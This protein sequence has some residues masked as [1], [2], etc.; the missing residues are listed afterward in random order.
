MTLGYRPT[1]V[2]E[3]VRSG[4]L[5]AAL[6]AALA[7]LL[8]IRAAPSPV[9]IEPALKSFTVTPPKQVDPPSRATPPPPRHRSDPGGRPTPLAPRPIAHRA[10]PRA[11]ITLAPTAPLTA[12]DVSAL[13]PEPTPLPAA[14]PESGSHAQGLT[15]GSG[16]AGGKGGSGQG[17]SGGGTGTGNGGGAGDLAQR[18]F[19]PE[20]EREFVDLGKYYP[21]QARLS[22]QAGK[23]RLIC[24]LTLRHQLVGCRIDQETPPNWG[25]AEAA[26]AY[27]K[28]LRAIPV[29]VNGVEIDRARVRFTIAFEPPPLS[30][31]TK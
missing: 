17:G 5:S 27:V 2:R 7:L 10:G 12:P 16:T 18:I 20:W 31:A 3:R 28:V 30:T 21:G 4:G 14:T 29:R 1:G 26:L 9:P 15:T 23:V 8:L 25:F 13:L 11:P 24:K 6:L 19:Q 22:R